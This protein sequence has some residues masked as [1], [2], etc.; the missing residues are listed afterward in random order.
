MRLNVCSGNFAARF[1]KEKRSRNEPSERVAKNI[2]LRV[3][4]IALR[5]EKR[6]SG[7]AS[8]VGGIKPFDKFPK[9]G[10]GDD[11]EESS[12]GSGENSVRDFF[13]KQKFRNQKGVQPDNKVRD[14][15]EV[16][17]LKPETTLRQRNRLK[18]VVRSD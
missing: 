14:A 18:R 4:N 15:V 12:G 7:F 10:N 1:E 6:G 17:A 3:P 2:F 8:V 16:V 5:A 9:P 13:A 11:D